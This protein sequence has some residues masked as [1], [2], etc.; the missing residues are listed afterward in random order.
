MNLLVLVL[1]VAFLFF[2]ASLKSRTKRQMFKA[3]MAY[4]IVASEI[5]RVRH[6]MKGIV[7]TWLAGVGNVS[8]H[9]WFEGKDYRHDD[10]HGRLKAI[11]WDKI[12]ETEVIS[13]PTSIAVPLTTH[14]ARGFRE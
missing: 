12:F 4:D 10:L 13:D 5:L 8:H 1:A 7:G 6:G 9:F 11:L 14:D 3:D 2:V